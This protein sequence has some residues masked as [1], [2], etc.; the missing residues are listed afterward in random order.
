MMKVKL[1]VSSSS[2]LSLG[3]KVGAEAGDDASGSYGNMVSVE[4]FVS[5]DLCS[6]IPEHILLDCSLQAL[7]SQ[8]L[9]SQET[10]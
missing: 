10:H 1:N 7:S 4:R 2:L 8:R 5:R 3:I 9:L 6:A